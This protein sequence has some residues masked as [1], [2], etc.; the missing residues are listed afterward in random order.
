MAASS[1]H[2][3]AGPL[4]VHGAGSVHAQAVGYAR[5]GAT[6]AGAGCAA[7]VGGPWVVAWKK[8]TC[9]SANKSSL[10]SQKIRSYTDGVPET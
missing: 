10:R 2:G 9:E 7:V 8:T 5:A 3:L 1:G 6:V 4:T